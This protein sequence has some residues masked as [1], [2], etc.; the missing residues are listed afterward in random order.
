[1]TNKIAA[2]P[3][4]AH[5]YKS[6]TAWFCAASVALLSLHNNIH[7]VMVDSNYNVLQLYACT[8]L[9]IGGAPLHSCTV[10]TSH[11]SSLWSWVCTWKCKGIRLCLCICNINLGPAQKFE[12]LDDHGL[13]SGPLK[14]VALSLWEWSHV[15]EVYPITAH[16]KLPWWPRLART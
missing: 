15:Y 5:D 11:C 6:S 4:L 9:L 7:N 13:V 12:V 16:M 14:V 8:V 1:M 3:T 2:A 10:Y